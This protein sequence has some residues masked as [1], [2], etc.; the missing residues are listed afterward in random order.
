MSADKHISHLGLLSDAAACAKKLRSL[1]IRTAD[2]HHVSI[3]NDDQCAS[4]RSV[5]SCVSTV[6][7]ASSF[8]ISE[9]DKEDNNDSTEQH[10][11]YRQQSVPEMTPDSSPFVGNRTRTSTIRHHSPLPIRL[12]SLST[13]IHAAN[14]AEQCHDQ[15][16]LPAF[17]N[18]FT[19]QKRAYPPA[20][21]PIP[22]SIP[23]EL[24]LSHSYAHTSDMQIS[25]CAH[26]V[27][28]RSSPAKRK[29]ICAHAGCGKAFTTSGHLSRHY[30]I[31]TGEKNYHCLYPG[32]ASRFS[33]QDNMMQHYRTHLSPRSRRGRKCGASAHGRRI[34]S[35]ASSVSA[36]S[37]V[38]TDDEQGRAIFRH[39]DAHS[40]FHPYK[41]NQDNKHSPQM[42]AQWPF[43]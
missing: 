35:S 3:L 26:R 18:S 40:A 14:I 38:S 30:R 16:S 32:C 2:G 24:P 33:R 39:N 4:A 6:G 9:L 27:V 7:A 20:S 37:T 17:G 29:Y 36:Q 43:F 28:P 12:P 42:S 23:F 21:L 25:P 5:S 19:Q 31:H 1:S 11:V 15:L 41:R 8:G 22:L 13:L 10:S 34:A